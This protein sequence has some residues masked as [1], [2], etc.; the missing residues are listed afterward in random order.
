VLLMEIDPAAVPK[1]VTINILIDPDTTYTTNHSTNLQPSIHRTECAVPI[2]VPIMQKLRDIANNILGL[3]SHTPALESVPL[4][5]E[6]IHNNIV[7]YTPSSYNQE[8]ALTPNAYKRLTQIAPLLDVTIINSFVLD[9]PLPTEPII[10]SP[11][12]PRDCSV[13]LKLST[14]AMQHL[15]NISNLIITRINPRHR[16]ALA[17]DWLLSTA[18]S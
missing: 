7:Q 1:L 3:P 17:L 9:S 15:T 4:L 6:A 14:E 8:Y 2:S 10:Y 13:W 18:T 11:S 5:L 16:S 12:S